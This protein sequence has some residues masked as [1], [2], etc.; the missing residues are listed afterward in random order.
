LK[1]EKNPSEAIV[2]MVL[3][4]KIAPVVPQES[5]YIIPNFAISTHLSTVHPVLK[6]GNCFDV[7]EIKQKI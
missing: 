6:E 3:S 2:I 4:L 1:R 5:V 7:A